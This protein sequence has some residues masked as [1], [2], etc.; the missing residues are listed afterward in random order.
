M[1]G[2]LRAPQVLTF[3]HSLPRK[4]ITYRENLLPFINASSALIKLLISQFRQ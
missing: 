2:G 3:F 1:D 4:R